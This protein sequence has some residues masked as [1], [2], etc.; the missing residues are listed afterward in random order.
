M[1]AAEAQKSGALLAL[2]LEAQRHRVHAEAVARGR[3]RGI[4]EDVAEVRS[5]VRAAHLHAFHAERGI[6]Q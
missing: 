5:A 1:V 4:V 2:G 6:L 3:L